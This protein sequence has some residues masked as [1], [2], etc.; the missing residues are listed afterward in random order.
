MFIIGLFISYFYSKLVLP[1]KGYIPY[2]NPT[3]YP[4]MEC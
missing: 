3:L 1:T 2:I 4:I